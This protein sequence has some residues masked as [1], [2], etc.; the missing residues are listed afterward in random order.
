GYDHIVAAAGAVGKNVL[1][2]AAAL[3]DVQPI[4]DVISIVDG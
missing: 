1:P 2:R 3:L 4:P